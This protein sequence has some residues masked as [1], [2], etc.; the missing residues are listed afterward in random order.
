VSDLS[1]IWTTGAEVA[2]AMISSAFALLDLSGEMPSSGIENEISAENLAIIAIYQDFASASLEGIAAGGLTGGTEIRT[3]EAD[4]PHR[5]DELRTEPP[6]Y[7]YGRSN[8][9]SGLAHPWLMGLAAEAPAA[10]AQSAWNRT[11]WG[12]LF[13]RPEWSTIR[14]RNAGQFSQSAARAERTQM[15]ADYPNLTQALRSGLLKHLRPPAAPRVPHP[16]EEPASVDS[17]V[18]II[19]G[20][21]GDAPRSDRPQRAPLRNVLFDD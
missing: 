4:V 10:F 6:P 2:G 3:V 15:E 13:N 11:T 9:T 21:T 14:R 7:E 18:Q 8:Q 17:G 20:A 19:Y 12:T 1:S 16:P 5:A